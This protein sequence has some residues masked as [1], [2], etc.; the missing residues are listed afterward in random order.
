V[1]LQKQNVVFPMAGGL[2]TKTDPKQLVTGTMEVLENCTPAE[3]LLEYTKRNGYESLAEVENPNAIGTLNDELVAF[4]GNKVYSYSPGLERF[5][6]R[7][8]SSS[9][10]T[11]V[12]F[13]AIQL[14]PYKAIANYE[15]QVLCC[16]AYHQ[17]GVQAF[18]SAN[19]DLEG[20]F[21]IIDYETN[22]T[23]YGPV[24]YLSGQD[25]APK[26]YTIGGY[27]IIVYYLSAT[28]RY[29][30]VPVN[31]TTGAM[32][33][34]VTVASNLPNPGEVFDCCVLNDSVFMAWGIT[35][36]GVGVASLDT[37]LTLRTSTIPVADT[38]ADAITI[39]KDEVTNTLSIS[40]YD[41]TDVS[42]FQMD[43]LLALTLSV[44]VVDTVANVL[45]LVGIINDNAGYI[46]YEVE[47]SGTPA[48]TYFNNLVKRSTITAGVAAAGA[49]WVRSV[50]IVSKPFRVTVNDEE[51]TCIMVGYTGEQP[52]PEQGTVFIL[53][54]T[55][56]VI[57][58]LAPGN[59]YG[60][61]A[62]SQAEA[63][64][65]VAAEVDMISESVFTTS[66]LRAAFGYSALGF[67][68]SEYGVFGV[69]IDFSN[70]NN[71]QSIVAANNMHVIGGVLCMYDGRD[72]VEHGFNIIPESPTAAAPTYNGATN[73]FPTGTYSY[74]IV[75]EWIDAQGNVHQSVP[76]AAYE[77]A[78]VGPMTKI[79]LTIPTLRLTQKTNVFLSV[80]R[81]TLAAPTI[82]NRVIADPDAL[83]LNNPSANSISF[84]DSNPDATI[85]AFQQLYTTGGVVPN[86]AVP[87][88]KLIGSFKKRLVVLPAETL[89]SYGLVGLFYKGFRPF[90]LNFLLFSLSK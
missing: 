89:M 5:V 56:V 67:Q 73:N 90:Q 80:Y 70:A 79:T 66:F 38:V 19:G 39:F 64:M 6:S 40:Y 8:L 10:T 27:F 20:Y 9:P 52:A 22:A 61:G 30:A 17:S 71:Y 84:E 83:Q 42:Y 75:F 53:N 50:G 28:L 29:I 35:G 43:T 41:G 47:G 25:T 86:Y 45:T 82:F 58:K 1:A 69:T 68:Y 34:P 15:T 18:V 11:E 14:D 32:P 74:I 13:Q 51:V 33:S 59:C 77:V 26:V 55:A 44:T 37:S 81:N 24:K 16:S 48:D 21:T 62:F 12:N 72:F 4:A 7:K 54:T 31:T 87:T 2:D 46:Y 23:L 88:P 60:I 63:E 49:V 85:I 78:V 36:N 76:S 3:T 65:N 57:G